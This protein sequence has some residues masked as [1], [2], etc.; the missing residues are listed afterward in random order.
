M[1]VCVL[2]N[3]RSFGADEF[4]PALIWTVLHANPAQLSSTLRFIGEYRNPARLMSEQ[5]RVCTM[6]RGWGVRAGSMCFALLLL[7]LL[8]LLL[9][10]FSAQW[11]AMLFPCGYG[12]TLV[13]GYWLTNLLSAVTFLKSADAEALRMSTEEFE[14]RVRT[15]KSKAARI[16]QHTVRHAPC[17][18][19]TSLP[20]ALHES[21]LTM[22]AVSFVPLLHPFPCL[23]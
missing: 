1:R 22:V 4:L 19:P 20:L 2:S 15:A 12:G 6:L 18:C 7:L 11:F 8:L 16:R 23:R 3:R 9:R 17:P 21:S 5:V 13:Q 14:S 10:L